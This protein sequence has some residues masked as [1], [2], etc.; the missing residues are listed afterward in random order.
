MDLK[1]RTFLAELFGTYALVLF[2]AGTA[3]TTYLVSDTTFAPVGGATLAV[4][5]AE[6]FVLAVALSA[7][8]Y[9]SQGYLNPAITLCL[10]VLKRLDG[11][12]TASLI[13]AQLL[14]AVL[15]GLTLRG[16]F[17]ESV[18]LDA[19]LGTP[20]LKALRTPE[21]VVTFLALLTGV[22]LELIFTA[23]V[24][25]A[26]FA[27]LIDRRAPRLGGLIV[28]LAQTAVILFGFHL[29]GGSANPARWFGPAVWQLSL[30][31]PSETS[32]LSDHPVY[33]V[34]PTVGALV[35]GVFY[36][37]VILPPEKR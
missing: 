20:Y 16:L 21:G 15:A 23:V 29:T 10:W 22:G 11:A 4:A 28:G 12:L 24:T 6:G 18:L 14:G 8:A 35:A 27:T 33:W 26:V 25:I 1:P 30:P 7:T 36:T 3:C 2:G 5:L 9:V 13:A 37:A 19:H 31:N 34:G 32:R 17:R